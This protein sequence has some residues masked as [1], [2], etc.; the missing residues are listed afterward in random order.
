MKQALHKKGAVINIAQI[1]CSDLL[2]E[3]QV[4]GKAPQTQRSSLFLA[5]EAG[6]QRPLHSYVGQLPSQR[7]EG[8]MFPS[9]GTP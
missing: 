2:L 8:A 3:F 7:R 9:K 5:K 4:G 6:F 1:W